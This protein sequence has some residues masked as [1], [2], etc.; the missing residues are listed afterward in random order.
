MDSVFRK[1]ETD[2]S[3][4]LIRTNVSFKDDVGTSPAYLVS[5]RYVFSS[6]NEIDN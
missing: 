1:V 2:L 5:R 3:G 4:L 6:P